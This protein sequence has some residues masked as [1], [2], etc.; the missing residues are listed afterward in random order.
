M[1]MSTT[2]GNSM[3]IID[4]AEK[5]AEQKGTG[6]VDVLTEKMFSRKLLVW[7]ISTAFLAFG[8]INPDEWVS[9]SLGYIGI[10]G[11]A[12]LATKWKGAGK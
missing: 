9:I 4:D 10:Q 5:E 12:D 2:E 6:L 1:H 7:V 8:K 3:G 11:V